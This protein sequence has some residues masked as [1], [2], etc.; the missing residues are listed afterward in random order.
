[1]EALLKAAFLEA[2][3]A[4]DPYRL[5]AKALPPW[6]PDL[7]LAVGKAARGEGPLR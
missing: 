6:R 5:T 4:T 2:L 3:R 7:V 1:M